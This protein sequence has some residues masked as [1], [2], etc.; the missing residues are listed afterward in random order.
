[1][2]VLITGG[3]GLLGKWVGRDLRDNGHEVV[4]VDRHLPS[5]REPGIS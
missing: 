2:R 5:T 3:N 4:S 1:M